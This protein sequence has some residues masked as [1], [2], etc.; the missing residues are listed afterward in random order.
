[1]Y[2]KGFTL[3]EVLLVVI[4]VAILAAI[5]LP[6]VMYNAAT[7]RRQACQANIAAINS[8][9]E[10]W[11]LNSPTGGWPSAD[12]ADIFASRDYFPDN[13]VICPAATAGDAAHSAAYTLDTLH[14]VIRAGHPQ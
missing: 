13:T 4:I 9:V 1:M 2:R 3:V 10:L 11:H 6:R 14:R 12:L 7:A 5:V 8:Q